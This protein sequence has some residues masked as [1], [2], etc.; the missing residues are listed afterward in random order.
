MNLQ[1]PPDDCQGRLA[2]ARQAGRE[3]ALAEVRGKLI[4]REGHLNAAHAAVV[5]ARHAVQDVLNHPDEFGT[6]KRMLEQAL[7]DLV[8]AAQEIGEAR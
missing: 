2:A 6:R 1:G 4:V 7:R 5:R 3:R 8:A